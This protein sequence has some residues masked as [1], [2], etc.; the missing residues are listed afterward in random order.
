M[1][2]L[3]VVLS[4]MALGILATG[5]AAQE[6]PDF[7][8]AWT[9]TPPAATRG[10]PSER[11]GSLGSGWGPEFIIT[12]DAVGL[13]VERA[14]FSRGDLQPALTFHYVLD[15][16]QTRNTVLMGRGIQAQVSTAAWEG[17]K[18]VITTIH[19]FVD[20]EDGETMTSEVTQTLSL[21]PARLPAWP[22]SLV[23]ETAR[24]GV[25]GGP[26]SSTRT[27]YTRN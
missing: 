27:V 3:T 2:R 1:R 23:I 10:N 5:V 4:A 25:L 13:T 22:P 15:G 16:S 8:G 24:S 11:R 21:E 14:F 18:L 9:G 6:R 20:P 12:H 7:S 19:S 26:S 17:D